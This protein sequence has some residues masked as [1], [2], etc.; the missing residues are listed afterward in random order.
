MLEKQL[1]QLHK[2]NM[3]KTQIKRQFIDESIRA[4]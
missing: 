3:N 1:H 4:V 2:S